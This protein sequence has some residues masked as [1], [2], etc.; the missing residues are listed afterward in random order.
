MNNYAWFLDNNFESYSGKWVAIA[1][2]KVIASSKNLK[3]LTKN[4][5]E[6]FS[7]EKVSFVKVP[8]SNEALIYR[9]FI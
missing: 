9:A 4:V 5:Q 3:E 6:K 7:S 2:E 1:K 8:E